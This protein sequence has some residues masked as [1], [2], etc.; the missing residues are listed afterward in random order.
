LLKDDAAGVGGSNTNAR[1]AARN[2]RR[3]VIE[4]V[5]LHNG[6]VL[7]KKCVLLSFILFFIFIFYLL[8]SIA[9]FDLYFMLFC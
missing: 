3:I 1:S 7:K 9:M 5:E 6:N 8:I 4:F 2:H